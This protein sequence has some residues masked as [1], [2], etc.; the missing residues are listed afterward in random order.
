MEAPPRTATELLASEMAAKLTGDP[1]PVLVSDTNNYVFRAETRGGPLVVKV[2]VDTDI[3]TAYL[4]RSAMELSRALP[5]PAIRDVVLPDDPAAPAAIVMDHGA[6]APRSEL[7][8]LDDPGVA[9]QFAELLARCLAVVPDLTP[10]F[11]GPGLFKKNARPFPELAGF[12]ESYFDKYRGRVAARCDD[13]GFLDRLADWSAGY[14]RDLRA[15]AGTYRTGVVSLDMNQRN[16]LFD[17]RRIHV[18]NLPILGNSLQDHS[19]GA[20]LAQTAGTAAEEAVLARLRAGSLIG[21]IA[22]YFDVWMS[23]GILSFHVAQGH[24]DLTRATNWGSKIS[25]MTH[26]ADVMD[27]HPR[28]EA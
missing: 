26:I 12:V 16:F 23:I 3:D 10:Y 2:I 14:H 1:A 9:G 20:I 22:A 8:V 11:E 4:V 21:N 6:G 19:V 7:G 28:P 24:G 27:R 15:R 5:V 13:S 17:G 25:L 18:L